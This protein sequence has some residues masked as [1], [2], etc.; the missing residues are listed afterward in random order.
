MPALQLACVINAPGGTSLTR[1]TLSILGIQGWRAARDRSRVHRFHEPLEGRSE[2]AHLVY[3][4]R[5][6]QPKAAH[7]IMSDFNTIHP[8]ERNGA[9][10]GQFAFKNGTSPEAVLTP[11]LRTIQDLDPKDFSNLGY[12]ADCAIE[13]WKPE[14][15]YLDTAFA[16]VD[17]GFTA[18]VDTDEES[19][20]VTV[21]ISAPCNNERM[22]DLFEDGK[23]VD[24]DNIRA[25]ARHETSDALRDGWRG[26]FG[27]DE[28]NSHFEACREELTD[29][30]EEESTDGF[31]VNVFFDDEPTADDV[32]KATI[33]VYGPDGEEIF[34]DTDYETSWTTV[35]G[36]KSSNS[37]V[38]SDFIHDR[39]QTCKKAWALTGTATENES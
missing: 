21:G 24:T 28:A 30:A 1:S 35:V 20:T 16:D 36:N 13:Q 34:F 33:S 8:R 11:P 2:E 10:A 29:A 23:P 7:H 26:W 32:Q 14:A 22:T 19:Q 17:Y 37:L 18:W 6:L 39:A 4:T 15:E 3:L 12:Y 5:S 25:S 38:G 27:G 9:G 31:T